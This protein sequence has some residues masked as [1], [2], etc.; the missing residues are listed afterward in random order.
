ML[1]KLAIAVNL[2]AIRFEFWA[3]RRVSD[4]GNQL[5]P[6]WSVILKS[7]WN[8]IGD[9]F[10]SC[11]AVGRE[12][13]LAVLCS[14]LCRE[15]DWNIRIGKQG[16]AVGYVF[17][18]LYHRFRWYATLENKTPTETFP[19]FPS[20]LRFCTWRRSGGHTRGCDWWISIRSVNNTYDWRK[21][22]KRFRELFVF[23]SR[24]SKKTVVRSHV[25]IF[26]IPNINLCQEI[27][28][29]K[30]VE[31]IKWLNLVN[32]FFIGFV[33]QWFLTKTNFVF[34]LVALDCELLQNFFLSH[35]LR[36]K[37]LL[38]F[39]PANL[40]FSYLFNASTI[41]FCTYLLPNHV[42]YY[43]TSQNFPPF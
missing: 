4:G 9:T 38:S 7:V 41:L 2:E 32:V 14:L 39:F 8:S 22:W 43:L 21:F 37:R 19:K 11:D 31:F 20:V 28:R 34:G 18:W 29:L 10:Y 1:G 17:I 40:C 6:L 33:K 26:R 24:E 5:C 25:L 16:Y 23:Q 15:L 3:E 35:F 13:L 36:N 12:L 27:L 30:K 42:K